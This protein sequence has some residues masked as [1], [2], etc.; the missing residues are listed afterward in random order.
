[1]SVLHQQSRYL[2]KVMN[3]VNTAWLV[4]HFARATNQLELT[5]RDRETRRR[6]EQD[7]GEGINKKCEGRSGWKQRED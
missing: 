2:N 6:A 7:K 1:M 3:A 5:Q 4:F